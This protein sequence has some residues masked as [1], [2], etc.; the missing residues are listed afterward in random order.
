MIEVV[1]DV[2]LRSCYE[3]SGKYVFVLRCCTQEE[4]IKFYNER[5][6]AA[7]GRPELKPEAQ[8]MIIGHCK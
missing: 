6:I 7:E 1:Y 3:K 5:R 2:I 4:I 8:Y